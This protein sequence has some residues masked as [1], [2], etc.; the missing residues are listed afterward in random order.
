MTQE[1]GTHRWLTY[2]IV[3]GL[4]VGIGAASMWA[5]MSKPCQDASAMPDLVGPTNP[6]ERTRILQERDLERLPE[7][8]PEFADDPVF[9]ANWMM[10]RQII[11]LGPKEPLRPPYAVGAFLQRVRS[12]LLIS[13]VAVNMHRET[14]MLAIAYVL[15]GGR[16]CKT[17]CHFPIKAKMFTFVNETGLR[18]R[19][20]PPEEL[21]KLAREDSSGNLA[22]EVEY[23]HGVELPLPGGMPLAAAIRD[24]N[25]QMSNFVPANLIP[26]DAGTEHLRGII[27]EFRKRPGEFR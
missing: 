21:L 11:R 23:T 7:T 26:D 8:P 2:L 4:G 1:Q 20:L 17:E 18:V 24:R 14:D 19:L 16:L 9:R 15:P 5:I 12:R 10:A 6:S 22:V 3:F 13:I 27:W 25:G